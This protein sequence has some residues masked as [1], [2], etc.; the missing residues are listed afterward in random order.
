MSVL[1]AAF[2][3]HS[4]EQIRQA[5]G[6]GASAVDPIDGKLPIDWLIEM[7]PR[8]SR[9]QE[10]LRVMLDAGARI[11]DPQL[12]AILLDDPSSLSAGNRFH[13]ECAYTC[14]HDVA[15]LHVCAEYN[16][17]RCAAALLKAGAEVN[18][19]AG[20]DA[21]GIGG[22]TPLFHTVNSNGNYCRP[23]MDLLIAAGA[24]LD[25]RLQALVWGKGFEWETVVFDVSPISYAQCGL[26]FQFHRREEIVY[27][28][29][30]SLYRK[31]H[32]RTAPVRNVPNKYLDDARV[33][34]PRL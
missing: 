29:I 30:D 3:S 4:P 27:S 31:R 23:M 13:L 15:A 20:I 22:Q 1:L 18:A 9:F 17:V 11:V 21:D 33:F 34:P 28:N 19:R 32:G 26:Y 25:I 16:S 12:Q 8:T 7:Y 24:D 6:E 14:L 10:C 2:E 5:L